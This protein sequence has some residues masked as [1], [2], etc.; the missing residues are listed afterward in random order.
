MAIGVGGGNGAPSTDVHGIIA[1]DIGQ[2]VEMMILNAK[3]SSESKVSQEIQKIKTKMDQMQEKI[4]VITDRV[5]HLDPASGILLK[6]D[7]Q[8]SIA[9][10]EEVWEG[11]VGTLKHELWQTIQ[12]HNH[13][14]DLMKHHKDA[15]DQ[16]QVRM[17]ESA[18]NPELE[19]IHSQLMQIDKIMQRE[20]AKQ[21]Q[22]DQFMQRLTVVQQQLSAG[23]SGAWGAG[24]MPFPMPAMPAMPAAQQTAGKKAQRKGSKAAKA[25]KSGAV[26]SSQMAQTLRA[27]APEF[28]PTTGGWSN[29]GI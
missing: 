21:Q 11:E 17:E 20:Q 2:Q 13:N 18:P 19:H 5:N 22:M 10:L 29:D 1:R 16:I 14:A 7:L 26:A 3:Q 23:L 8:K 24:G 15:I 25:T 4:K 27:E 9:K 6:T 28:V 12:A